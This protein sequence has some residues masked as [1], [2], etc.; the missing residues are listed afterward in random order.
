MPI[1][2]FLEGKRV[3]EIELLDLFPAGEGKI[4][5]YYG[6]IGGGKTYA[7]SADIFDKARR[8]IVMYVNWKINYN[9]YDQTKS[10]PYI[11]LSLILPWRKRFYV[12]PKENIRYFELSDAWAKT[13]GYEDFTDWFA[14]RTDCELF[15]DEGHIMFDS[16]QGTRMPIEKRAAVL[17]TRHFDRSINIISQRPTAIHVSMRA[18]VNVFY[19]CQHLFTIGPF[20]RFKRTEYQDML[21]ETVD[22]DEEKVISVKWYWGKKRIFDAYDTKYLRGETKASQ[23]V[24]FEAY[25]IPYLGRWKKVI[26]K[27]LGRSTKPF[28]EKSYPQV[29][30]S[31]AKP[32]KVVSLSHEKIGENK[33][34][35]RS[36]RDV[37]KVKDERPI[38]LAL[39]PEN[40]IG[41]KQRKVRVMVL[42]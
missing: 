19:K 22:E 37:E 15:M 27:L 38:R 18:N 9:G 30:H 36:I 23:R 4:A 29:I 11:I 13:Q 28:I 2:T 32:E 34:G 42:K 6:R 39:Q 7:A 17:H 1:A 24:L 12:F 35:Q 33:S 25:D 20:V 41:K 31:I 10:L 3:K 14:S 21:G 16:Y 26:K 40:I 8:G 5:Q